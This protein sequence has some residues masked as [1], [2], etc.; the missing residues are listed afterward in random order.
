MEQ[1]TT[2]LRVDG[3]ADPIFYN[4][5]D[6][7]S[8]RPR[9]MFTLWLSDDDAGRPRE[10]VENAHTPAVRAPSLAILARTLVAL[11]R[12]AEALPLI[13]TA[14]ADLAQARVLTPTFFESMARLSFIEVLAAV[15]DQAGAA[16][17]VREA[18]HWIR[19]RAGRIRTPALRQTYLTR[20]PENVQ[21][22]ALGPPAFTSS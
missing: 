8:D 15:G 11:R 13:R 19:V 12:A 1:P 4:G 5:S 14:Q 17:A 10:A 22:L 16:Q 3:R 20:I 6:A 2:G 21:I 9:R 7:S 18:Q